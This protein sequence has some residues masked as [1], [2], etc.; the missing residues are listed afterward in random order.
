MKL[1]SLDAQVQQFHY[2]IIPVWDYGPL[3]Y[4]Q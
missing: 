4:I 1:L 2:I 3:S